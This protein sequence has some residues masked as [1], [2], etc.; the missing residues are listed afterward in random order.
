[1]STDRE[2]AGQRRIAR[3]DCKPGDW[4]DAASAPEWSTDLASHVFRLPRISIS[5]G[6]GDM[7]GMQPDHPDERV[8]VAEYRGPRLVWVRQS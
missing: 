8:F 7:G 3:E 5:P 6:N 1:M 2:F 4:V